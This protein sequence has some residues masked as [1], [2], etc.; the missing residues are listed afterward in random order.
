MNCEWQLILLTLLQI[1]VLKIMSEILYKVVREIQQVNQAIA[2]ILYTCLNKQYF[3]LNIAAVT[4]CLS[5]FFHASCTALQNPQSQ[6]LFYLVKTKRMEMFSCYVSLA[7][8]SCHLTELSI[9]I[10][11]LSN[12]Q[13][14]I[15]QFGC[16]VQNTFISLVCMRC[17]N[18]ERAPK[19]LT[20]KL[21]IVSYCGSLCSLGDS[22][23]N[24]HGVMSLFLPAGFFLDV[25][26]LAS[27]LNMQ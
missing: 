2:S 13:K 21:M 11:I 17:G 22:W 1:S 10:Q 16:Y 12:E 18:L 4:V 19:L 7:F 3:G 26:H 9:F 6:W 20:T 8:S 15:Y 14:Q 23:V 25:V 27:L 24:C 5:P